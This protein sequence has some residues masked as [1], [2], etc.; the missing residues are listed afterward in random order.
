M[1]IKDLKEK[2]LWQMTGEKFLYLNQSTAQETTIVAPDE[3]P[4]KYVYG[5]SGLANLF[6]CSIPTA[7]RIK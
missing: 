1:D 6:G 2:P 3:Q 4:K 5:L 7:N